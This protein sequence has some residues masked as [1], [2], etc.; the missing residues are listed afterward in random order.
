MA[1]PESKS[2]NEAKM[3]VLLICKHSYAIKLPYPPPPQKNTQ[4]NLEM[5]FA[6]AMSGVTCCG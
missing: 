1:L 4:V 5:H 2:L 6:A 3:C